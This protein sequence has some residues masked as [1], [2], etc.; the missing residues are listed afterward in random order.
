MYQNK[1]KVRNLA[2]FII[3][4][5]S[6]I[7][8]YGLATYTWLKVYKGIQ[9]ISREDVLNDIGLILFSFLGTILFF[10]VNKEFN[11][12]GVFAEFMHC[13]KMNLLFAAVASILL[14]FKGET[15]NISRGVFF[16]TVFFNILFMC[17]GHCMFR[18]Y[19]VAVYKKRKGNTQMFII[20]TEDRAES[21][22]DRLL[23]KNEWNNMVRAVAIIDAEMHGEVIRGVPVVANFYDMIDYIKKEPIDD[24]FINVPYHTGRSLRDIIM[25]IENM[26]ITVH[27][28]IEVL[29]NFDG[30][31]KTVTM[32]GD[33]P[34]ITFANTF[35]DYNK[36]II[37]RAMDIAGAIIGLA[38]TGIIT[39]FLAPPLLL[40]SKGPLFFKQRRVGKN[41]RYFDMYKFR[42]MYSDAEERKQ[43]LMSKNEMNGLMFKMTDDPR[44]TKV[45]KFIRKTSIDEMP[46]FWNVLKGE[47]SLVGTRPPTVDEFKK[48]EGYH[49]RR[50]STKPGITGMWQVSGRND[51]E[52]FEEVVKLDL[53]YIDNWCLALDIKIILKTIGIVF[54]KGCKIVNLL[55][56]GQPLEVQRVKMVLLCSMFL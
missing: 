21:M 18:Y 46:Q 39:I 40:E 17:L 9:V 44:I 2:I 47:M 28:N 11:K 35:F 51:I 14:V 55:W 43:E 12:R 13:I 56:K 41:G 38:F 5:L 31:D 36:L 16:S 22:L 37:K 6:V 29:E 20:T 3:D 32:L 30:F 48:Y 26:G 23:K 49:K 45:G 19:L 1:E 27:L 24:V 8:S 42:S 50:L 52:D 10:N 33:I 7:I 25:Q 54:K 4:T 15:G 53:E 34:V